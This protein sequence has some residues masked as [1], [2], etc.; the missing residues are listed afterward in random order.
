M[1][2]RSNFRFVRQALYA[3]KRQYGANVTVCKV[4]D[5]DTDYET[6]VKTVSRELYPVKRAIM[7]PVEAERKVEQGI[8]QLS[9]NKSFVSQAGFDEGKALF[10][11]DARDLPTGF[12]FNLD[13]Y[14]IVSGEYYLVTEVDEFE[15]DAGWIIKTHL[16]EGADLEVNP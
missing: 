9:A 3:L 14:V 1:A 15:V 16:T 5:T 7:L 13:D 6:G 4:L 12:K 2:D 8:A 11:F 10:I